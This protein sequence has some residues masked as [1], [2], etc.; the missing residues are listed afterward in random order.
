MMFNLPKLWIAGS[1]WCRRYGWGYWC[2][3]LLC[4]K[5]IPQKSTQTHE[6]WETEREKHL[7][8]ISASPVIAIIHFFLRKFWTTILRE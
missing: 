7:S 5:I 8:P 4:I 2:G 1:P 6:E 3:D